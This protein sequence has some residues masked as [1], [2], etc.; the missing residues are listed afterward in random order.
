MTTR[1]LADRLARCHWPLN[2]EPDGD[3][4]PPQMFWEL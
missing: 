4:E 3:M 2:R 1:E